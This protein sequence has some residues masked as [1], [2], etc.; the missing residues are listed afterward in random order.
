MY[1]MKPNVYFFFQSVKAKLLM[2]DHLS[3]WVRQLGVCQLWM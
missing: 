1:N 3:A 2:R